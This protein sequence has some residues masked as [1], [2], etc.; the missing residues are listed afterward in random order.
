MIVPDSLP[1]G[2]MV[3]LTVTAS[4]GTDVEAEPMDLLP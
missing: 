4:L 3:K 1:V 2:S